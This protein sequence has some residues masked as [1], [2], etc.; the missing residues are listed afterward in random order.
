MYEKFFNLSEL[1]FQ[2]TPDP[3]YFFPS[4][5]HKR[6]FDYLKFGLSHGEGFV[7]VTGEVGAGKTTL[8]GHLLATLDTSRY[9]TATVVTTQLGADDLLRMFAS[10]FGVDPEGINKATILSRLQRRFEQIAA[11]GA[12]PVALV[13]E[14]Q[15]LPMDALEELRMLS[16][17]RFGARSALMT[18]LVGQP[19]FRD[20][21][22]HPDLAQLRQRV[23]VSYHLGPLSND[24]TGTYVR[25]RL[26][27]TGWKDDPLIEPEAISAAYHAT[28]GVPRLI[29]VLFNRS[30]LHL[31]LEQ[32]HTL[33]AEDVKLVAADLATEME[34]WRVDQKP[35]LR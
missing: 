1:P 24:E 27:Q 15:N 12:F 35:K 6:A 29:N 10:G 33:T 20:K 34:D 9:V 30:L 28:G 11:R 18:I 23:V 22:A 17:F 16:N 19:Q 4:S 7:V 31:Y 3:R 13:D 2:L 21:M 25:H 5:G 26:A 8:I 14:S 32:R